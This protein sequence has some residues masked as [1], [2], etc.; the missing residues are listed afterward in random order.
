[1]SKP[2][3][4]P[5]FQKRTMPAGFEKFK[6]ML[7]AK[8]DNDP[9]KLTYPLLASRKIDGIRAVVLGGRLLTRSLKLVPNEFIRRA[10]EKPEFEGFDGELVAL[11]KEGG[12]SNDFQ[13]TTSAVM[14]RDGSPRVKF[15][16]FDMLWSPAAS[17]IAFATRLLNV[18]RSLESVRN[19]GVEVV[20]VRHT[21]MNAAEQVLSYEKH[22]LLLGY[23]GVMLRNPDGPYKFGRSTMREGSLIKLKRFED[24]EAVI[25]G[26]EEEMHNA[27]E[28]YTDELGRTKRS[29]AKAGK[30]GKG[31][32]G[33]FECYVL[34]NERCGQCKGRGC[35]CCFKTGRALG[36]PVSVG[37][38][39][40]AAQRQEWWLHRKEFTNFVL[41]FRHLPHGAKEAPRHPVFIGFR[42]RSDM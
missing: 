8:F 30:V 13:L 15:C 37:S 22:C 39:I 35:N 3:Y 34:L 41:K 12:E 42:D 40:T 27:N 32:L 10:L 25:V 17:N 11:D 14:K 6:P 2:D 9:A 29:S 4:A 36:S 23:E 7:A 16:V 19:Y 20:P 38:G 1:M 26:F 21:E 31:T 5:T 24:A 18:Q 28:A 33:A